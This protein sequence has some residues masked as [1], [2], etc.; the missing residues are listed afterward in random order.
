M[1]SWLDPTPEFAM[2]HQ[3]GLQWQVVTA[4]KVELRKQSRATLG[5]TG[6]KIPGVCD[7]KTGMCMMASGGKVADVG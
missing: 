6:S 3:R 1:A 2:K 5:I 7:C 4:Q